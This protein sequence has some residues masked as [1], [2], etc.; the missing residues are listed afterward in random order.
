ML[1]NLF[2]VG[3]LGDREPRRRPRGSGHR[4]SLGR[5]PEPRAG[6]THPPRLRPRISDRAFLKCGTMRTPGEKP[7]STAGAERCGG[8][9]IRRGD[10]SAP[11][12]TR[13]AEGARETGRA[14]SARAGVVAP[15]A[16]RHGEGAGGAGY[17]RCGGPLPQASARAR[18]ARRDHRPPRV[19]GQAQASPAGRRPNRWAQGASAPGHLAGQGKTSEGRSVRNGEGEAK[20]GQGACAV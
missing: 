7:R 6:R 19:S 14:K 18:G 9:R 12:C 10:T 2:Q 13:T 3:G 15:A 11:R 16:A 1:L 17:C 20:C 8:R 5:S 4:R